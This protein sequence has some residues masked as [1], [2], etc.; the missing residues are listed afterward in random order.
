MPGALGPADTPDHTAVHEFGHL[1]NGDHSDGGIM[2][3]GSYAAFSP[4]T[5]N[6]IRG[7]AHP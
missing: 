4:L 5:I 1:F 3:T 7:V 2:T 6:Q